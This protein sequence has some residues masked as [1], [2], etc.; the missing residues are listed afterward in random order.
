MSGFCVGASGLGRISAVWRAEEELGCWED[1]ANTG[2]H[3]EDAMERAPGEKSATSRSVLL[4]LHGRHPHHAAGHAGLD[5]WCSR[6]SSL[7][8][9]LSSL[10]RDLSFDFDSLGLVFLAPKTYPDV[11]ERKIKYFPVLREI[12]AR[13]SGHLGLTT[14]HVLEAAEP[15]ED[16]FAFESVRDYVTM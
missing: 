12:P 15:R 7:P 11:E 4:G 9:W 6:G 16:D 3:H 10:N 2:N 1:I 14:D 13:P 8:S 5:K